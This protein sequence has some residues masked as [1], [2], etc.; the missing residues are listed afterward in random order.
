MKAFLAF[1]VLGIVVACGSGDGSNGTGP[2]PTAAIT[3]TW[4]LF[5]INGLPLPVSVQ[6]DS[7]TF[8]I[9]QDSLTIVESGSWS[10]MA[11]GSRIIPGGAQQTRV[12]LTQGTWTRR[13]VTVTLVSSGGT[14]VYEGPFNGTQLVLTEPVTGFPFLFVHAIPTP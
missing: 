7:G 8:I 1:V 11:I 14:L 4:H 9:R 3:G 2:D 6:T 5:S 10:E 13:G 12:R